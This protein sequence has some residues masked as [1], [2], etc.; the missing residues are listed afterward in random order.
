MYTSV[1]PS[2]PGLI[3]GGATLANTGVGQHSIAMTL[4]GLAMVVTGG[5]I[6]AWLTRRNRREAR[7]AGIR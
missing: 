3:M 7:A 6:V 5:V 1:S 4:V 2:I